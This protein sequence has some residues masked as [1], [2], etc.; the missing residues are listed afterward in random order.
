MSFAARFSYL[1][2][3]IVLLAPAGLLRTIPKEYRHPCWRWHQYLPNFY[4]RRQLA[5]LLGV[6]VYPT[7]IDLGASNIPVRVEL[8][9]PIDAAAI[10]QWQFDRH[11]GF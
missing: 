4:L 5:N 11:L 9:V 8:E 2:E 10:V 7:A 6:N 1:L 3:S